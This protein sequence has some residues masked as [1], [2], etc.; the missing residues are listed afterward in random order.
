M[1][2]AGLVGADG[3]GGLVVVVGEVV[4]GGDLGGGEGEVVDGEGALVVVAEVAG[5]VGEAEGGFLVAGVGAN[6][7]AFV[8][9]LGVESRGKE[10]KLTVCSFVQTRPIAH[11]LLF[12]SPALRP[13]PRYPLTTL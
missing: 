10:K 6:Q 13:L 11:Y 1:V 7:A 4:L 9:A 12:A 2:G 5:G 3:G 8:G